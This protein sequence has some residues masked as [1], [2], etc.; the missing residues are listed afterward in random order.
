MKKAVIIVGKHYAGKS[1]TIRE[2]LKP[3]VGIS[4]H[5]HKFTRN[6]QSGFVLSQ[7]F[8]EA[9][10]DVREAVTRYS[11]YELLVLSTRP[12]NESR[13]RL[14]E[15]TLEFKKAGYRVNTV[16]VVGLQPS[17]YYKSKADEIMTHLD[18]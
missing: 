10:R 13:S 11:Y 17:N 7:S 2:Y 9:D 4:K 3:K 12:V 8:E 1:K 15:L 5:A 18:E 16:D 6:G 14:A